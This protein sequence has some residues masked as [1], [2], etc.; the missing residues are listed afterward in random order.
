MP[1]ARCCAII[2]YAETK[3]GRISCNSRIILGKCAGGNEAREN[4]AGERGGSG[5]GDDRRYAIVGRA[6]GGEP[7]SAVERR[8]IRGARDR[9]EERGRRRGARR[10]MAD[11][12][13]ESE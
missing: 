3:T 10:A 12:A 8:A 7:V 1:Y 6:P 2:L 13:A 5:R 11:D 4:L 9:A